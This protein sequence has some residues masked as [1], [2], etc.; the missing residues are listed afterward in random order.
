MYALDSFTLDELVTHAQVSHSTANTVLKRAPSD[1]FDKAEREATHSR[2][3]QRI[4]RRLSGSGRSSLLLHLGATVDSLDVRR[5]LTTEGRS[6]LLRSLGPASPSV[7]LA[8]QR[9]EDTETIP[10]GLLSAQSTLLKLPKIDDPELTRVLREDALQDLEWAEAEA[11]GP[12]FESN[13]RE[14]LTRIADVRGHL[15]D[16]R[17]LEKPRVTPWEQLGDPESY[18]ISQLPIH[19]A[20]SEN[21]SDFFLHAKSRILAELARTRV[22]IVGQVGND[23]ESHSL[24]YAA[25]LLLQGSLALPERRSVSAGNVI[26]AFSKLHIRLAK[27]ELLMQVVDWTSNRSVSRVDTHFCLAVNSTVEERG[28]RRVLE[29][30][31]NQANNLTVSVLDSGNSSSLAEFAHGLNMLY[32]PQASKETMHHWLSETVSFHMSASSNQVPQRGSD[33]NYADIF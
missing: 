9:A 28:V 10:L 13:S 20:S 31:G 30:L 15:S 3:G 1:W 18:D 22:C 5:S 26:N 8:P 32:E 12:G 24:A 17:E 33:S 21:A 29:A 16:A 27:A 4:K 19:S 11:Q 7:R 23:A 6:D 2:G 14:L 25:A